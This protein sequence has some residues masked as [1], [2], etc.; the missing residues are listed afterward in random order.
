MSEP[1]V[2]R[3]NRCVRE[4]SRG[5]GKTTRKRSEVYKQSK[6]RIKRKR[7]ETVGERVSDM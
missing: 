3:V 6:E 5:K 7:Q 2:W 1:G 4:V